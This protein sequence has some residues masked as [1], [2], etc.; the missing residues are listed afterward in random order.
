MKKIL[1]YFGLISVLIGGT[2]VL[3]ESTATKSIY[4]NASMIS[5][6]EIPMLESVIGAVEARTK[7]DLIFVVMPEIS[8]NID[9]WCAKVAKDKGLGYSFEN[10]GIL[11][12]I[13]AST[14]KFGAYT[15]QNQ[16]NVLA[17]AL[18][19][20][21]KDSETEKNYQSKNYYL[22]FNKLA[23]EIEYIVGKTESTPLSKTKNPLPNPN[24]DLVFDSANLLT[25]SEKSEIIAKVKALGKKYHMDIVI[26][27]AKGSGSL[28]NQQFA[29]NYFDYNNFADNGICLFINTSPNGWYI[30]T[31]GTGIKYLTDYGTNYIGNYIKSDLS[32]GN[33]TSAFEKFTEIS[34]TFL[35]QG[36]TGKSYDYGNTYQS[37]SEKG[38]KTR[39]IIF[40]FLWV[41]FA[42]ALIVVR[43][44]AYMMNTVRRQSGAKAYEHEFNLTN[45]SDIY[46]YSHTIKTKIETSSGG[47]SSSHSG[48]SGRSHGGSGGSF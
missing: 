18:I 13:D 3:A 46:L 10:G 15:T 19:E 44:L 8:G 34:D 4:D 26:V 25:S 22:Y 45:Q 11:C 2:S 12:A 27:T 35:K 17:Q 6:K 37:A 33:F 40:T 5:E 30:S 38:R 28:T 41:G 14:N 42:L 20:L 36:Q 24:K 16:K 43:V 1:V 47:G 23:S 48:S 39:T 9:E 32:D 29:D 21:H 31:T 7:I